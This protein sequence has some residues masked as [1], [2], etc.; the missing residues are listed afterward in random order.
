MKIIMR[1]I[2]NGLMFILFYFAIVIQTNAI[3]ISVIDDF[4]DGDSSDWTF[5]GGNAAGG[6]GGVSADRPKEGSFYLS[7]GWGGNG[8]ASGFYGGAF[9]NLADNGQIVLPNDP[10]F[11]V[12]ILNQSDATIDQYTLEITLR[13][14]LNGNGWTNGLED[15]FRLDSTFLS[16]S[17][18]DQWTLI[19]A[20][21][22][23]FINSFTGG[24]GSFD[25]ALDEI[26]IVIAGVV[27][28]A[29]TVVEVDFDLFAFS[30]GGPIFL[31]PPPPIDAPEPSSLALLGLG[32]VG[33]GFVRRIKCNQNS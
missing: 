27:G 18:N 17:F 21:V 6:G 12:W 25:G 7:T 8:T 5:F 20:P 32:L 26:V 22:S 4:E 29:S 24:D 33:L 11:N 1:L 30:S 14:D 23:S 9:K 31:P 28:G 15:S 19:S 13:E 10:W 3:P 16:S 2:F